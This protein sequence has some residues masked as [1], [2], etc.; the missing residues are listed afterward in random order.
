[1]IIPD[2]KKGTILYLI[3]LDDWVLIPDGTVIT[4][5]HGE[6]FIKRG[7]DMPDALDH[8]VAGYYPCGFVKGEELPSEIKFSE[9][10][11]YIL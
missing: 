5:T 1:M 8:S 7:A 9:M 6:K 2:E 10:D 3:G 4:T 11:E